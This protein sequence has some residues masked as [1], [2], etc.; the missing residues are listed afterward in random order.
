MHVTLANKVR[1]WCALA[2]QL[3]GIILLLATPTP[4]GTNL[5]YVSTQDGLAY[6]AWGAVFL[7]AAAVLAG[8]SLYRFVRPAPVP[9]AYGQ[10]QAYG[11]SQATGPQQASSPQ[12]AYGPGPANGPRQAYDARQAYGPQQSYGP[13]QAYSAQ[14]GASPQ[15][16]ASPPQEQSYGPRVPGLPAQSGG[17]R[18]V[19]GPPG[20]SDEPVA[21]HSGPPPA[22]SGASQ[23]RP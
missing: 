1:L 19:P 22:S 2:C 20:Q 6:E 14:Q 9:Q 13:Q 10:Q 4:N 15:R 23:A 17:P 16:D 18:P 8:F 7:V 3:V 21:A 11:P 5:V 12:L